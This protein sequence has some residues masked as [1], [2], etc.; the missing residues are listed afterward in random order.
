M[1]GKSLI[2][3]HWLSII[4]LFTI[5]IITAITLYEAGLAKKEE[6]PTPYINHIQALSIAAVVLVA[7]LLLPL[8]GW[9]YKQSRIGFSSE[10]IEVNF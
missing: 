1:S 6:D 4:W 3:L 8:L 7:V 5:L 10:M 2:G 9:C